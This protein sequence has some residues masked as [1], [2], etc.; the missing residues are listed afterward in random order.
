MRGVSISFCILLVLYFSISSLLH[1]LTSHKKK[2][3]RPSSASHFERNFQKLEYFIN[4]N[5][6][7]LSDTKAGRVG[8]T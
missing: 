5:Q 8:G 3:G 4:Y 1:F 2:K 6:S 7:S